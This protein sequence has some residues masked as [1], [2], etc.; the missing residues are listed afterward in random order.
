MSTRKHLHIKLTTNIYQQVKILAITTFIN[1]KSLLNKIAYLSYFNIDK[2]IRI[3][4]V[5]VFFSLLLIFIWWIFKQNCTIYFALRNFNAHCYKWNVFS[6]ILKR[7]IDDDKTKLS[8]TVNWKI[9]FREVS[10]H[11][12]KR[13]CVLS[14]VRQLQWI[15]L[16]RRN[17]KRLCR[18]GCYIKNKSK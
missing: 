3:K 16:K 2:L 5:I 15:H 11:V 17:S 18:A 4:V 1:H 14:L 10:T 7:W 12:Q 6:Y 9:G 8:A 13:R